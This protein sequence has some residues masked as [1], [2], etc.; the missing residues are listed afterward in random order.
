MITPAIL[1][2]PAFAEHIGCKRHYGYEL[3]KDGRLVMAADGK[4]VLV[5]ESIARIAATRDPAK[6]G[7]AE[8]HAHDRGAHVDTGHATATDDQDDPGEQPTVNGYNFQVSKAK[9]EHYA[10]ERE[11][12]T[13]LK[14]AG[15]LME[16]SEVVAAF[17]VAGTT[18]RSKLEGWQATLP[19]QLAGRDE[20]AIRI[21]LA[22]QVERIL[23]DLVD[24]F[25]RMATQAD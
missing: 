22:D 25:G 8:R 6:Q 1:S 9:R 23:H 10:A 14:E 11:H 21:V 5:A 17:A 19:P 4:N 15:Q 12:T 20:A 7:V 13:Y 18:L 3:K 16:R 24:S 2:V